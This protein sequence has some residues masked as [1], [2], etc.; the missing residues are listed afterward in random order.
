MSPPIFYLVV[1]RSDKY[2]SDNR[3]R[4]HTQCTYVYISGFDLQVVNVAISD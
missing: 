1:Q 3:L 4:L 2:M